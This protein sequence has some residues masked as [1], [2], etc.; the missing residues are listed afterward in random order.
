M[1]F[2]IFPRTLKTLPA[3]AIHLIHYHFITHFSPK[4]KF[5]ILLAS[6]PLIPIFTRYKLFYSFC[7]SILKILLLLSTEGSVN[8][9]CIMCS[10]IIFISFQVAHL[11]NSL[12]L[13]NLLRMQSIT[14]SRSD[15]VR[16]HYKFLSL[17]Y[18]NCN[19]VYCTYIHICI[20]CIYIPLQLLK[21]ATL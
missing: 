2:N 19:G 16:K 6:F 1:Y 14:M 13:F 5:S 18:C 17:H 3:V 8:S 9:S 15:K 10:S 11:L 20:N 7:I 12:N 4:V 21:K